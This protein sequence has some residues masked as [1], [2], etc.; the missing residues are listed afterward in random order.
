MTDKILHFLVCVSIFV[1]ITSVAGFFCGAGGAIG[2]HIAC[3]K[4]QE[5]LDKRGDGE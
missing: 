5:A 1:G 4:T 2:Y 3:K